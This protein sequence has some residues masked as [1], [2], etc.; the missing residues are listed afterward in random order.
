MGYLGAG[1]SLISADSQEM[2]TE[3][4]NLT[5]WPREFSF[6]EGAKVTKSEYQFGESDLFHLNVMLAEIDGNLTVLLYN[7]DVALSESYTDRAG[8]IGVANTLSQWTNRWLNGALGISSDMLD[9]SQRGFSTVGKALNETSN[10]LTHWSTIGSVP[11]AII[12]SVIE[13]SR[14]W[15]DVCAE[16]AIRFGVAKDKFSSIRETLVKLIEVERAIRVKAQALA[17]SEIQALREKVALLERSNGSISNAV[18]TFYEWVNN[19]RIEARK[20]MDSIGKHLKEV[21]AGIAIGG[22]SA[23][24]IYGAIGLG[25][26]LLLRR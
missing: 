3:P 1:P 12:D 13:F 7:S 21:G 25:A 18:N 24:V 10:E 11:P 2:K 16:A 22:V 20:A 19:A 26:F 5:L 17:E 6:L 8:M 4:K 23:L 15:E 9:A 14:D